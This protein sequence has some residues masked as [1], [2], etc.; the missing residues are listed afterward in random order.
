MSAEEYR[1][2]SDD[3]EI[4]I[5]EIVGLDEDGAP[6]ESS[7]ADEDGE[8]EVVFEDASAGTPR[9]PAAP[10][11]EG[12]SGRAGDG[13][14]HDRHLRLQA[15][16]EN[17]KKRVEREK[18]D[19]FIHATAQL[20]GRLLPVL[21]NFERAI[22]HAVEDPATAG[23]FL[24]G[25]R[26][27]HKQLLDELVRQGLRPIDAV[28]KPFDPGHHEAVATEPEA[29]V[30]PNTVLMEFQRGYYFRDRLLRP[31]MVKVSVP[32]EGPL[33]DAVPGD[34]AGPTEA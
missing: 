1:P 29:S 2:V 22:L 23:G 9:R 3:D 17:F 34:G 33:D 16:F 21:D 20:V 18:D 10:V 25:V 13:E 15:D 30:P 7:T 11:A 8:V 26:L 27:I 14:L 28:G 32:V 4:E 5:L 12:D 19:F 31:A 6:V 24:E